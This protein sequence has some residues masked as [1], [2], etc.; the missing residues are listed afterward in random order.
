MEDAL[1]AC[2][3]TLLNTCNKTVLDVGISTASVAQRLWPFQLHHWDLAIQA[4]ASAMETNLAMRS[5]L[6]RRRMV[7]R[8][9]G[10]HRGMQEDHEQR[11][12]LWTAQM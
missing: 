7:Q 11:Q 5:S 6:K 3:E 8:R 12:V 4:Q 9:R 10:S 1:Y 2:T